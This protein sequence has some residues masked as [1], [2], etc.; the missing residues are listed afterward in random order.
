MQR[1]RIQQVKLEI[2]GEKMQQRRL[3]EE[4]QT[5]EHMDKEIE[6]IKRSMMEASQEVVIREL[7]DRI[8][9]TGVAGRKKQQGKGADEQL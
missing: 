7:W 4:I 3:Q 8:K 5:V 1:N 6:E 9:P 2:D